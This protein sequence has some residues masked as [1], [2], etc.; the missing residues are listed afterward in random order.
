[1]A[2]SVIHDDRVAQLDILSFV[3]IV[4]FVPSPASKLS[5][6]IRHDSAQLPFEDISLFFYSDKQ[7]KGGRDRERFVCKVSGCQFFKD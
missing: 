4:A 2:L 7:R 6:A 1:M 3:A 5:T